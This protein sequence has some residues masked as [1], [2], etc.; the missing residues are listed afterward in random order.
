M[1][2]GF[3]AAAN[4]ITNKYL[5]QEVSDKMS[6][7]LNGIDSENKKKFGEEFEAAYDSL[8]ATRALNLAMRQGHDHS[9][10]DSFMEHASRLGYSIDNRVIDMLH[11]QLSD[12]MNNK[13][14][15]AM[16]YAMGNLT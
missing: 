2:F 16:D 1:D 9:M 12:E 13:V 11:L 4:S 15:N 3:L 10:E 6:T 8:T 7:S 14:N 5:S